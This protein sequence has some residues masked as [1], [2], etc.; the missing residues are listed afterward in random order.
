MVELI[1]RFRVD[2]LH[3]TVDHFGAPEHDSRSTIV[4]ENLTNVQ[5][6]VVT[7]HLA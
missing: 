3:R 1:A 4:L 5:V 2:K 6:K 7:L